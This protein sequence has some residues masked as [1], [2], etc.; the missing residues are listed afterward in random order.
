MARRHIGQAGRRALEGEVHRLQARLLQQQRHG[1]VPGRAVAGRGVVQLAF[2]RPGLVEQRGEVRRLRAGAG[3]QHE[4]R[5]R[6]HRHR[7]QRGERIDLQRLAE[8][9]RVHRHGP[10][11]AHQQRVAIRLRG[12]DQF[13]REVAARPRAVL[14]HHRLAQRGVE[15]RAQGTGDGIRAAAGRVGKD[16]PQGTVRPGGLG[17]GGRGQRRQGGRQGDHGQ[18]DDGQGGTQ[19]AAA[20]DEG[21][22]RVS[23]RFFF[24]R[25]AKARSGR[26]ARGR[27]AKSPRAS[28]PGQFHP[29]RRAEARRGG[30]EVRRRPPQQRGQHPHRPAMGHQHGVPARLA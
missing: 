21:H 4:L 22:G 23:G 16:Q 2:L 30:E 18:G 3:H 20:R 26:R 28:G 6:H 29:Q 1:E 14:H 5:F 27:R 19:R 8:Q 15:A 12:R 17:M 9:G 13:G 7:I 10:L 11:V 24:C 25:R